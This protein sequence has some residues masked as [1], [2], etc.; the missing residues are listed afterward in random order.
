MQ[1]NLC[2]EKVIRKEFPITGTYEYGFWFK[3][4]FQLALTIEF[5][6]CSLGC[7]L[8]KEFICEICPSGYVSFETSFEASGHCE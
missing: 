4:K 8:T 2:L 1:G 3:D 6:K 7:K 5:E